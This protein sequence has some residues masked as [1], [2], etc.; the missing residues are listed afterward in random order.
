MGQR[1]NMNQ[2]RV[3]YGPSPTGVP[4][5]GNIRTALFNYLFAKN[6]NGKFLLRIEDT[7]QARIVPDAVDKIKESLTTLNLNWDEVVVVQSKRLDIYKKYLDQLKSTGSAYEDEGAWRFK[8]DTSKKLVAWD[9]VV[10]GLVQFPTNVLEDFIIVKSDGFPTYHFASVV[11]D[12]DMQ[13][14]HVL[15]GDEWISSTPKHLQLYDAFGWQPPKFVHLP[16]IV[17]SDKKKLSKREGA[18]STLEYVEDGYLP[19]AIVNFLALLGWSPSPSEALKGGGKREKEIFSLGELVHAFSLDRINKNSPI[20]NLE[21]LNWFNSQW[22]RNTTDVELVERISSS[23]PSY[24]KSIIKKLLP[25]LKDRITTLADF[26]KIAAFFFQKPDIKNHIKD[27]SI[28]EEVLAKII[29]DLSK[30]DRWTERLISQTVARIMDK[31]NLTK[32]QVYRSIGIA[33][34]GQLV[35]PPIFASMEVLGKKETIERLNEANKKKT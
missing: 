15:R 24:N 19:E 20:F 13:I 2:I 22:I 14:S 12:H 16:P 5:I 7:D 6:Q 30:L 23:N 35:T 31:E 29:A 4:H 32:A 3:R 25:V 28:N 27:I 18:K 10:H 21:K 34:S 17:G 1:Q 33:L 11:D 8:V 26:S 9:D